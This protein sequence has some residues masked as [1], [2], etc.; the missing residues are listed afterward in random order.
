MLLIQ[1]QKSD[2]TNL[3]IEQF[4]VSTTEPVDESVT[5]WINPEGEI[6]P[7]IS[8]AQASSEEQAISLSQQNPNTIYYWSE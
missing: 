7:Y 1:Q 4:Q 2:I 8:L 3:G 5:V 6:N